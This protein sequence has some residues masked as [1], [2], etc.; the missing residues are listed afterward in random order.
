MKLL[1]NYSVQFKDL[2][3]WHYLVVAHVSEAGVKRTVTAAYSNA[4]SI[5]VKKLAAIMWVHSANL[6]ANTIP[7]R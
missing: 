3:G 5:K 6:W 2:S 7:R 1:S 4:V